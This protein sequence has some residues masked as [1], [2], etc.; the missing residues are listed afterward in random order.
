MRNR[1]SAGEQSSVYRPGQ[2]VSAAYAARYAHKVTPVEP[3]PP[4]D[5]EEFEEPDYDDY[6][7]ITV[8]YGDA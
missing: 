1:L 8:T 6:W 3:P 4:E 5:F 7:E 2:F